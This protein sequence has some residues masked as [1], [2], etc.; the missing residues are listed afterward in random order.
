[1]IGRAS[2]LLRNLAGRS[3]HELRTRAT[4]LLAARAEAIG[5]G[6]ILDL[7]DASPGR[8]LASGVS[9]DPD[10][11]HAAFRAPGRP[12]FFAGPRDATS[13]GRAVAERV[14]EHVATII[15]RA[16]R[17]LVGRFDLLGHPDLDYGS[18]MDWQ[19]DPLAGLSAPLVHWSRVPYL[20]AAAVGDHKVVWEL[21]RQQYL[22]TLAQAWAYTGD[23]RYADAA[24]EHIRSW[25]DHNPPTKVGINWASSLEVAFRAMSWVWALHM[26]RDSTAIGPELHARMLGMLHVHGRHLESYLSTYFSPN[27]HLTGEALGL[28]YLGVLLPEL[29]HAARWRT[30]GVRVLERQLPIHVRPDGVYFEQASQYHRYTTEIYLHLLLLGEGNGIPL[31]PSVREAVGAM[32]GFLRHLVRPDGT[33]PLLGDDDGGRLVQLDDRL[34]ADV[35]S[36]LTIGAVVLGRPELAFGAGGELAAMGWLLGAPGLERFDSLTPAVPSGLSRAFPDGGFYVL[37]DG[38]SPAATWAVVD[39]GPHGAM[40]CGHAHADALAIELHADGRPILVDSGT[41]SYPGPE[42]NE[43]RGTAAHNAVTVDG[44]GSS[45]PTTPFQWGRIAHCATD[46]WIASPRFTAFAGAHDGFAALDPPVGYRREL[47]LL[48]GGYLVVRDL[49]QVEGDQ[50]VTVHWHLAPGLAAR[51]LPEVG[52]TGAVA[53][54][55]DSDGKPLLRMATAATAPAGALTERP[56][57]VSSTY[58]Q[59][60]RSVELAYSQR[61]RGRREIVTCLVPLGGTMVPTSMDVAGRMPGGLALVLPLPDGG[62]DWLLLGPG[63]VFMEWEDVHSD[64]EWTWLRR[65]PGRELLEWI[66]IGVRQLSVGGVSLVDGVDVQA[67]CG[68]TRTALG[69]R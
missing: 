13:T 19:R 20:D 2:R 1:M 15:A 6:G 63:A 23:Q 4:Q 49:I 56:G 30:L 27:T 16:D 40:N 22:V 57:W 64:A 68:S 35:R 50:E 37:R 12:R 34:P 62:E 61:A 55:V 46:R 26:L 11:L 38:W 7:T 60:E 3:P 48:H 59:R 36:L 65:G 47:L 52:A 25:I 43:F 45:D 54:L 24:A 33:I 29:R 9:R 67:W 8:A 51:I 66:A 17:I 28:V 42:R 10:V 18:P 69:A 44:R 39:C 21:N 32:F 41:Y 58:G 31:A 14:P 5:L 53:E